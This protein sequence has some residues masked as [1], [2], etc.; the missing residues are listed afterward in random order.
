[1]TIVITEHACTAEEKITHSSYCLNC[2]RYKE[3]I[4]FTKFKKK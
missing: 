4:Y 2:G 1:M 3:K